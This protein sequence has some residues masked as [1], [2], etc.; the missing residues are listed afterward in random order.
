MDHDTIY[1]KIKEGAYT[2]KLSYP[3]YR[4]K[5]QDRIKFKD[6]DLL[7]KKLFREDA[8]RLLQ[9]FQKDLRSYSAW[10]LGKRLTDN[11]WAAIYDK[12]WED[13][14]SEGYYQVFCEADEL[15]DFVATFI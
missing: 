15:L 4:P 2:S 1:S 3:P 11:Q 13:G 5:T 9:Q 6:Q 14:S 12:A 7:A 10:K 8:A